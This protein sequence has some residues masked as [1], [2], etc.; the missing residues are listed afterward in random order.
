MTRHYDSDAL[1]AFLDRNDGILD[2]AMVEKHLRICPMCEDRLTE[3]KVDYDVLSDPSIWSDVMASSPPRLVEYTALRERLAENAA[4]A[5]IVFTGL[6]GRPRETWLEHLGARDCT[7]AL[8]RRIVVAA[9][10]EEERAPSNSFELLLI[11]ETL[12]GAVHDAEVHDVLGDLWK[13]R[14][15]TL[16]VLGDYPAALTAVDRAAAL[17]EQRPVAAFD[18]AF[19][20]W[21]RASIYFQ[22]ERYADALPLAERAATTLSQFGDAAHAAQVRVLVACIH[23][24]QGSISTAERLFTMLLTIVQDPVTKA[25]V[26]ANIACCRLQQGD[27]TGAEAF[28]QRANAQYEEFGLDTEIVRTQWA[29]AIATLRRGERDNGMAALDQVAR[30]FR[31]RGLI[32]DAAEVELDAVAEHLRGGDFSSAA[33]IAGRLATIF[34][35]AE[36]RVSTARA[37]AYL[38]EAA[39]AKSATPELLRAVRHVLTHPEQPF[40]V[41]PP[42]VH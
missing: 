28:G 39:L 37:L 30:A 22:M 7:A 33:E 26:L 32:V 11:A 40:Q 25:R 12:A 27:L 9:R 5:E 4:R 19:T 14:A 29:F 16:M 6:L 1:L 35:G 21:S 41:P 15:N 23:Y 34:I 10:A 38:R 17:Y 36:A 20:D 13:E 24:E 8:V 2:L 31:E 18:L 3:I 42:P